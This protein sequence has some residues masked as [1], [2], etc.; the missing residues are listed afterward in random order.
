M[1]NVR[2][3]VVS[4]LFQQICPVQRRQK[5]LLNPGKI[6]SGNRGARHQHEFDRL[7]QFMLMLPETFAEQT[8]RAAA[9]DGPSDF[10][11]RHDAQFW[12]GAG[13]QPLPIGDETTLREPFALLPDAYE[14]TVLAEA[15]GAPQS[16]APGIWRRVTSVW[17]QG[18]HE[19]ADQTGVRRLRPTRR[20]L[21][22]V[23]RPLLVDLR[24]RNP[25]CRL[26]RIFDG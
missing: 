18:G 4:I 26:R 9:F 10:P 12:C 6:A 25:C 20:R 15:P 3:S 23:A 8:P 24:A 11:A 2:C 7:G 21:R 22:K 17:G 1:F 16:Q 5:I 19:Q 14:I 13:G